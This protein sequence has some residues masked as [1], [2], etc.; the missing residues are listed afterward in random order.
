MGCV[1]NEWVVIQALDSF[2]LHLKDKYRGL[3]CSDRLY[4]IAPSR[5]HALPVWTSRERGPFPQGQLQWRENSAEIPN[6]IMITMKHLTS[7]LHTKTKI[8]S[9]TKLLNLIF[10]LLKKLTQLYP[11][12]GRE[13]MS[14]LKILKQEEKNQPSCLM[15]PSV[16]IILIRYYQRRC[17]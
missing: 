14:I 10:K 8:N 2:L 16:E 12:H 1:H 7:C 9:K 6:K 4:V 5:Y 3:I 13:I 17:C 15:K 11:K